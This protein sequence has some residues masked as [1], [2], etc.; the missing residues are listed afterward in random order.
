MIITLL[1]GVTFIAAAIAVMGAALSE[2]PAIS[3]SCSLMAIAAV[4]FTCG[5][6]YVFG[7]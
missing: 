6:K 4:V 2:D 3:K 5:A 1:Q 7:G